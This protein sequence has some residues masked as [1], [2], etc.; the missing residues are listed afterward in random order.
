[1]RRQ[2]SRVSVC[3]LDVHLVATVALGIGI[4]SAVDPC[5]YRTL[6]VAV[7]R[8]V[9]GTGGVVLAAPASKV[10]LGEI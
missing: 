3:P 4:Q 2:L 9:F 10:H 8:A 6:R 7:S 1:M 5:L